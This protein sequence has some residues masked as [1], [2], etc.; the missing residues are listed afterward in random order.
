MPI[1]YDIDVE[2]RLVRVVASGKPTAAEWLAAVDAALA[3]PRFLP[4]FDCLY[5]RSRVGLVPDGLTL[6]RLAKDC[7]PALERFHGG[8]LA[9]VVSQP[10][11]Y[12]MMRMASVFAEA[13]GLALD[14]FWTETAALAWLG[15]ARPH[16]PSDGAADRIEQ[17]ST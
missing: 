14:V 12:G 17:S 9:V 11:V 16:T 15:G 1:T 4:G 3:D 5:D 2:R 13:L 10:V 7:A 8:R 6:R